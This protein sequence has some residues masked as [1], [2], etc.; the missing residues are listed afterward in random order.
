[1]DETVS[2]SPQNHFEASY[3]ESRD[4]TVNKVQYVGDTL[5]PWLHNPV[6]GK[7]LIILHSWQALSSKL[8]H[9]SRS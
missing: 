9:Q 2:N 8:L 5:R 7:F 6:L 3:R 1:M 4:T